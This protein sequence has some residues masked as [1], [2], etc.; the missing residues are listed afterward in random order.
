MTPDR[1]QVAEEISPRL[2]RTFDRPMATLDTNI[3]APEGELPQDVAGPRFA[4]AGEVRQGM[5]ARRGNVETVVFWD[6]P[7]VAHRPLYFEEVNLERHG[8]RVPLIQP[9]LSGAH[10]FGRLPALPYLMFSEGH[11]QARYT[12]GHY[13]PGSMAPYAWY[14]PRPSLEGGIVEAAAVTGLLFAFP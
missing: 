5:G 8:Y 12:L 1:E 10:F 3:N 9:V 11:R 13:Q 7:N 2:D 4:A 6:A 14:L